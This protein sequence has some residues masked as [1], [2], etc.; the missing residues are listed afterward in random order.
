MNNRRAKN[1]GAH[2]L[3]F[4]YLMAIA[5][6]MLGWMSFGLQNL[7]ADPGSNFERRLTAGVGCLLG[8]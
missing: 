3:Q 6:A 8:A 4:L 2:V 1:L 7:D 5:V